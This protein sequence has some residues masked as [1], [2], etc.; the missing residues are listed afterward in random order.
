MGIF[1]NFRYFLPY[2]GGVFGGVSGGL[3]ESGGLSLG[4]YDCARTGNED[5]EA[6]G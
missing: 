2:L 5:P 3:C 1:A 4:G 6:E